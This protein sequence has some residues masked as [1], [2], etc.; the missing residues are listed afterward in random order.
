MWGSACMEG[1]LKSL[2]GHRRF[3]FNNKALL[4]IALAG[5]RSLEPVLNG[6]GSEQRVQSS[7]R[8]C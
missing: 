6:P 8:S 3:P 1:G 7:Y 2:N 4:S 5:R